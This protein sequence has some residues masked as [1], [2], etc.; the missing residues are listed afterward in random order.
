M[1]GPSSEEVETKVFNEVGT[2][3]RLKPSTVKSNRTKALDKLGLDHVGF[4]HL[5]AALRAYI[6][7]LNPLNPRATLK[8][9]E[10]EKAKFTV[11]DLISLVK[12]RVGL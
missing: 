7:F 9:N 5:A 6:H 1:P 4:V 11:D 8:V 10:I 2:Y 3:A 12:K